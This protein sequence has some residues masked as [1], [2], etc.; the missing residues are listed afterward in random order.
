MLP[1][2]SHLPP[3]LSFLLMPWMW[4][5]ICKNKSLLFNQ[6][7]DLLPRKTGM[8]SQEERVFWSTFSSSDNLSYLSNNGLSK[9]WDSHSSLWVDA[10]LD[11]FIRDFTV[12]LLQWKNSVSKCSSTSLSDINC[13]QARCS[14]IFWLSQLENVQFQALVKSR[15]SNFRDLNSVFLFHIKK[16]NSHDCKW[17]CELLFFNHIQLKK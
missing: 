6:W 11:C 4:E 16:E 10:E 8:S 7:S 1:L 15:F 9:F 2:K 14:T 12:C 13:S 5:D 17:E 3:H